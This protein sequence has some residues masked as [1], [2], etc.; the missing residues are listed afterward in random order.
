MDDRDFVALPNEMVDVFV[1][2]FDATSAI[3]NT[4]MARVRP[5]RAHTS[6][7]HIAVL[8]RASKYPTV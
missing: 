7:A 1:S 3:Q 2:D 5:L 8:R 6:R 4:E